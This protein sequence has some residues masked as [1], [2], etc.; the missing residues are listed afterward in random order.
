MKPK[1]LVALN[2]LTVPVVILLLQ[3]ARKQRVPPPPVRLDRQAADDGI[4][5]ALLGD[6]AA[7]RPLLLVVNVVVDCEIMGHRW[8]FR[9]RGLL[10][11]MAEKRNKLRW[12]GGARAIRRRFAGVSR[13]EAVS[14]RAGRVL[15]RKRAA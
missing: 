6:G 14:T 15:I 1:P 11:G 4:D 8:S 12:L 7:L 10:G 9:C 3:D 13:A 2:H 5:A